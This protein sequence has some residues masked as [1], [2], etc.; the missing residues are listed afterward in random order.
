MHFGIYGYLGIFIRRNEFDSEFFANISKF[1][2]AFTELP[3]QAGLNSQA[4]VAVLDSEEE[5]IY[6]TE[7]IGNG[8][9]SRPR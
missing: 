9:R 8:L 4:A 5:V 3:W 7:K 6:G 2:R 1:H